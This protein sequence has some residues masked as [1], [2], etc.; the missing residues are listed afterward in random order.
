MLTPLRAI[1]RAAAR[2][3]GV[4]RAA[5]SSLIEEMWPEIIGL[6][7]ADH[8]RPAGLRGAVLLVDTEPGPWAQELIVQ[9]AKFVDAI[10]DRLG[11][12]VVQD[13]RFRQ[14]AVPFPASAPQ[15]SRPA[16]VD[17]PAR[18]A[19]ELSAVERAVWREAETRKSA[20]PPGGR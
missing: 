5:F 18:S 2:S 6:E 13:I 17:E 10:N 20:R 9:R 11:A 7:A 19:D 3:L 8:A 4:E 12:T 1:L 15:T 16:V 14:N